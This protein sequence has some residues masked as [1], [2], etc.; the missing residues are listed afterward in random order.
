[1]E[2]K[3]LELK[4]LREVDNELI[5]DLLE[6]TLI[7]DFRRG[8]FEIRNFFMVSEEYVMRPDLIAR[9]V[10]GNDSYV[11]VLLKANKISNPFSIAEGDILVVPNLDKF[12]AFY[13]KPKRSENKIE[14]TKAKFID[15]SKS[16][17]KDISRV[18]RL[19]A[20]GKN[21][22][23]GAKEITTPNKLKKGKSNLRF[24]GGSVS[25]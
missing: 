2:F 18:E 23:N 8:N 14:D 11:D 10:F 19:E 9:A 21:K 17:K 12:L 22:K 6:P 5:L 4:E 7:P 13:K 20:L 24:G 16:S 25:F 3:N 1:M 15:P